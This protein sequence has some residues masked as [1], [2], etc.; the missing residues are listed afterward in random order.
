[1]ATFSFPTLRLKKEDIDKLLNGEQM[2]GFKRLAIQFYR[3]QGDKFTLVAQILDLRRKKI[4]NSPVLFIEA[5]ETSSDTYKTDDDV[6]FLQ[7]EL[8]KNEIIKL[9]DHGKRDIILT[10]KKININP[11][12]VTY[13]ANGNPITPCPPADPPPQP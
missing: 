8:T 13:D 6:I 4:D 11:D 9:S 1:M 5:D 3:R 7:H 10:P 2:K 12:G